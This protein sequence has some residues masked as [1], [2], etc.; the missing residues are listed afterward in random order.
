MRGMD[1]R[2]ELL[3]PPVD[4]RHLAGI[5]AEIGQIS[6][7]V[8]GGGPADE[9]ITAFNERTG[10]D[11]SPLD[12]AAYDSGRDLEDFAREAARPA[13][14]KVPG[15]TREELVEI[16]RGITAGHPEAGYY[17]LL[18]D[19]NVPHPRAADLVFHPPARLREASAEAIVEAALSY[20]AIAL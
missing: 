10:H 7:L 9:A 13:R 18:F 20:R 2:P 4:H 12:F 1:L 3:P 5:R 17:L 11:Y 16:V 19:V 6:N 15:V 14:P 8:A